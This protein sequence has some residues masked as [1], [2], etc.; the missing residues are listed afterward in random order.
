MLHRELSSAP[1]NGVTVITV[2][3]TFRDWMVG[4]QAKLGLCA[5]V[6]VKT[7]PRVIFAEKVPF[8]GMDLVAIATTV[9]NLRMGQ[10]TERIHGATSMAVV[11]KVFLGGRV[12][13]HGMIDQI[14]VSLFGVF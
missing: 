10:P 3:Q 6:T 4:G 14:G 8:L 2:D 12:I 9:C 7:Q 11:A 1:V 5:G 13:L